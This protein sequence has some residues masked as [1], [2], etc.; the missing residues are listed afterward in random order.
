MNWNRIEGN[1]SELKG[2]AKRN[3]GKFTDDHIEN[4]HGKR[5]NLLG[6]IKEVYGIDQDEAERQ[7]NEFA[8]SMN[9][10]S[11]NSFSKKNFN[12]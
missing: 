4:T 9:D 3:W 12:K 8:Q 10:S 1:W 2:H 6:K 11:V 7:I 5:E